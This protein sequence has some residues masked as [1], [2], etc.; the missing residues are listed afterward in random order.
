[1]SYDIRLDEKLGPLIKPDDAAE[2]FLVREGRLDIEI[3]GG[4]TTIERAGVKPTGD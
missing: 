1:M 4:E 3:E 2:F